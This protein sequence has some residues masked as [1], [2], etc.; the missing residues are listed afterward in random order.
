MTVIRTE[1]G[2][3]AHFICAESCLF[4]RNTLLQKDNLNII[5]STVGNMY[6]DGQL[7]TIGMDRLYETMVFVGSQQGS[8]IDADVRKEIFL[9]LPWG[10]SPRDETDDMDNVANDMHEKHVDEIIRKMETGEIINLLP[11]EEDNDENDDDD[12]FF[13]K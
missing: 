10:V 2:W 6:I 4:R 3:P 9:N 7:K 11:T 1:R 5:V 12:F 8:Y 13:K